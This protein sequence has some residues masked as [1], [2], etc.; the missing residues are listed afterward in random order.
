M[1]HGVF[2]PVA[3]SLQPA[4]RPES[5]ACLA[6]AERAAPTAGLSVRPEVY[7]EHVVALAVVD[8]QGFEKVLVGLV[9]SPTVDEDCGPV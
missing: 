1:E 8:G 3:A 5:V 6:V 4:E 2:W 9:S 7:R